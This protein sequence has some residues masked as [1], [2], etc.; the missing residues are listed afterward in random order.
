MECVCVCSINEQEHLLSLLHAQLNV[1]HCFQTHTHTRVGRSAAVSDRA[2]SN[3]RTKSEV[4]I[5]PDWKDNV[6]IEQL[7][8]D[9][10]R[11]TFFHQSSSSSASE[12]VPNL[13]PV[14]GVSATKVTGAVAEPFQRWVVELNHSE[15]E[16]R[17]ETELKREEA[18]TERTVLPNRT[19]D[20]QSA[21]A[22]TN[23]VRCLNISS[24]CLK[25]HRKGVFKSCL[26][27]CHD[28]WR[29]TRWTC[30]GSFVVA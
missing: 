28:Y 10:R 23:F 24:W 20:L 1:S 13:K 27:L 2:H 8:Q 14:P 18:D 22:L 26:Q 4:K 9:C 19:S 3:I 17:L 16:Q 30:H 15:P 21:P 12:P 29:K 7:I 5:H 11:H 6:F 25:S